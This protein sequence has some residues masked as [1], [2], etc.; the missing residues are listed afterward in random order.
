LLP[1]LGHARVLLGEVDVRGIADWRGV[2]TIVASALTGWRIRHEPVAAT[3]AWSRLEAAMLAR[4]PVPGRLVGHTD[5][6]PRL[7]IL[8][9]YA[10]LSNGAPLSESALGQ[11]VEV[12]IARM[13]PDEGRIDVTNR[14]STR[15]QLPLL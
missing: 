9:L 3:V 6:G 7:E 2:N 1:G 12:R 10:V 14:L 8:G 11:E 13:N 4:R 5:R 15:R